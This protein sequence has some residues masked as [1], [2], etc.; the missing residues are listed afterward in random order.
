M[1]KVTVYTLLVLVV[2]GAITYMV[3]EAMHPIKFVPKGNDFDAD[4]TYLYNLL[5]T[6]NRDWAFK[7]ANGDLLAWLDDLVRLRYDSSFIAGHKSK[8][9]AYVMTIKEIDPNNGKND[10]YGALLKN[11]QKK[12]ET[13]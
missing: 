5:R 3:Y 13:K 8:A 4:D 6:D 7:T 10:Y 1:N 12:Y 11:L 2:G 9:A